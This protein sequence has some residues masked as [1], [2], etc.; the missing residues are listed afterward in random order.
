MVASVEPDSA[1]SRLSTQ[2][3]DDWLAHDTDSASVVVVRGWVLTPPAPS[4]CGP[5]PLRRALARLPR[6]ERGSQTPAM[7][8]GGYDYGKD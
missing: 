7:R 1:G 4:P 8:G 6:E 2:I 3:G 5:Q